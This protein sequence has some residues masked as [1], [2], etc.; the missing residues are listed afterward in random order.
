MA[1]VRARIAQFQRCGQGG[2]RTICAGLS[3]VRI[4]RE[5]RHIQTQ[6]LGKLYRESD[7]GLASVYGGFSDQ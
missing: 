5:I 7:R 2:S 3:G 4:H 1:S 6:G